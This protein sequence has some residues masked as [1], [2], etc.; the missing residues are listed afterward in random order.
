MMF[1]SANKMCLFPQQGPSD[2][3]FGKVFLIFPAHSHPSVYSGTATFFEKNYL[4]TS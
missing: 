2:F 4:T 1:L 3:F